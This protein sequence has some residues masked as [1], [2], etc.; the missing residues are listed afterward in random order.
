MFIVRDSCSSSVYGSLGRKHAELRR[1]ECFLKNIFETKY[2]QKEID[3]MDFCMKSRHGTFIEHHSV[4][5]YKGY[6]KGSVDVKACAGCPVHTPPGWRA[7]VTVL[8]LLLTS[9]CIVRSFQRRRQ[10]LG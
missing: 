6:S 9:R 5:T 10:Q 1:T 4:V 7:G 8:S 2:L 3:K